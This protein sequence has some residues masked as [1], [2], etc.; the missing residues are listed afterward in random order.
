VS[1]KYI[2]IHIFT[3]NLYKNH[4]HTRT[5]ARTHTHTHTHARARA[6]AY[7]KIILN[8]IYN[9]IN[10]YCSYFNVKS[11]KVALSIKV[12]YYYVLI[13]NQLIFIFYN[14]YRYSSLP[15]PTQ[16]LINSFIWIFKV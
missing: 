11:K 10:K 5:H 4:T 14:Y 7:N 9:C 1:C 15:F 6:R 2:D 8:K 12:I 3:Y 13:N 16:S